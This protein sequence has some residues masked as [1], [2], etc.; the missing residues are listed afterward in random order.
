MNSINNFFTPESTN[1]QGSISMFVGPGESRKAFYLTSA[2]HDK[3]LK[4]SIKSEPHTF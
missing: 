3:L 1:A 2:N 4:L